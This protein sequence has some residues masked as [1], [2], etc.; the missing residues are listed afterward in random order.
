MN[1]SGLWLIGLRGFCGLI[2][3]NCTFD[4][5]KSLVRPVASLENCILMM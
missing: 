1:P 4:F 2:W 5:W 3:E